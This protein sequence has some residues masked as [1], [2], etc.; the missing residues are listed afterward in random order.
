[1]ILKRCL[2]SFFTTL[3]IQMKDQLPENLRKID[4]H[5]WNKIDLQ[6]TETGFCGDNP[7]EDKQ[8]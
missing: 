4:G 5:I 3:T 6:V 2:I 8:S 1:M 7:S